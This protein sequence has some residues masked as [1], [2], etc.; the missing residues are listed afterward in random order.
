MRIVADGNA[1]EDFQRPG[2]DDCECVIALGEDEQRFTR[3]GLRKEDRRRY[4]RCEEVKQNLIR[5]IGEHDF[6]SGL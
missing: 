1:G 4:E 6:A 5:E 2:I 3:G